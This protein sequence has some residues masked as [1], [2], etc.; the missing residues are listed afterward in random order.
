MGK[1][2]RE[3]KH[4]ELPFVSVCT[5]TF[6]RRPFI[7]YMI[8]CF[9]H[10]DYPKDRIEWIIIDDGTDK[11]GDLVQHI[12]QVKYFA[13]NEKMLLG[14]KRNVMHDKTRGDIIVYMD[15]DDY[16]PPERICGR[17]TLLEKLYHSIC[18]TGF[19]KNHLSIFARP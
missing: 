19:L 13:Y 10:Q 16:Y 18:S 3:K 1:K 17:K 2:S 8:K 6:N 15:D 9:E 7:P 14:K 4:N 11:I 5:P 12:P